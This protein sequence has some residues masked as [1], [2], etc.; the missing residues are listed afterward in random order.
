MN[1]P[2]SDAFDPNSSFS[3]KE[4]A[5]VV[6]AGQDLQNK[7]LSTGVLGKIVD[8]LHRSALDVQ[9]QVQRMVVKD[10]ES[11]GRAGVL[12]KTIKGLISLSE[13]ERKQITAPILQLK[14][15]VDAVF[16][17]S[18]KALLSDMKTTVEKVMLAYASVEHARQEAVAKAERARIAAEA[19]RQADLARAMDDPGTAKVIVEAAK[20]LAA[21]VT[22]ESQSVQS[23]GVT[24]QV[25]KLKKVIVTD[26]RVAL[27]HIANKASLAELDGIVSLN[28]R[29]LSAFLTR[30]MGGELTVVERFYGF[31]VVEVDSLANF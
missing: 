21:Q 25:R 22:P 6:R 3:G 30:D 14:E 31:S 10:G 7:H 24:T 11:Y 16:T 1:I 4:L 18:H 15:S 20:E 29:A 12:L 28:S 2:L 5:L 9:S 17:Q 19:Q 26:M 13:T 23:H 8:D 27:E